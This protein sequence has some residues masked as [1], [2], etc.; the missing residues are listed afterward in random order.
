MEK[1]YSLDKFFPINN[2]ACEFFCVMI[3]RLETLI[4]PSAEV[5]KSSTAGVWKLCKTGSR[6]A[7]R[8]A[9]DPR[10]HTGHGRQRRYFSD[11][12]R[13]PIRLLK[14]GSFFRISST[15]LIEWITVE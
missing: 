10:Q 6:R 7:Q 9:K 2:L 8:P 12:R 14:V 5:H 1:I 15:F 3:Q 11:S 4:S 13:L